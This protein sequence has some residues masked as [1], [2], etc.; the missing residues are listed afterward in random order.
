[1][2]DTAL[3]KLLK[4]IKIEE[5][6]VAL[7]D[8]EKELVDKVIPNLGKR[9]KKKYDEIEKDLKNAKV[10][11]THLIH[12]SF[13]ILLG[14]LSAGFGLKGFLLPNMFID[15]G[16][17]GISLTIAE[18]TFL[19][20]I[21]ETMI[22]GESDISKEAEEQEKAVEAAWDEEDSEEENEE[23]LPL[24][25]VLTFAG[26]DGRVNIN[27]APKCVLMALHEG[28]SEEV[29][30]AIISYREADA[31]TTE[32]DPLAPPAAPAEGNEAASGEDPCVRFTRGQLWA[33]RLRAVAGT[34]R[35]AP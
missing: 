25:Q 13:F 31:E 24:A 9:A 7:K 12:D 22:Y 5:L 3:K 29:A 23:N 28:I 15:G 26:G 27:T 20:G 4:E 35:C 34:I 16:V 6:T 1:M 19:D 21:T 32:E 30:E 18:L 8:A 2:S 33:A 17:M 10:E 14:V 11:F